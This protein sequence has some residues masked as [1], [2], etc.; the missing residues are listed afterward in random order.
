[1]AVSNRY[2]VAW[3]AIGGS[4]SIIGSLV[5]FP[6]G[7]IAMGADSYGLWIVCFSTTTLLAQADFGIG[8]AVV[9]EVAGSTAS[10][11]RAGSRSFERVSLTF[12]FVLA[13]SLSALQLVGLGM[14]F[15]IANPSESR[16][17]VEEF[18]LISSVGLFFALLGRYFVAILQAHQRFDTERKAAVG[19]VALRAVL[20]SAALAVQAPAWV[21]A[22]A[23]MLGVV[24]PV[25]VSVW[26]ALHS[27]Y[28]RIQIPSLRDFRRH[29]APLLRYSGPVFVSAF[30]SLAAMQVPVYIIAAALSPTAVTAYSAATRIYQ[31]ARMT[32]GWVTGPAL[33]EVSRLSALGRLGQMRLI[34]ER[35]L[36]QCV[37][38][39]AA[40]SAVL[41]AAPDLL[42]SVWL[43]DD[44][45]QSAPV[46]QIFGFAVLVFAS[47]SPG[48]VLA[49]ALGRPGIIAWGAVVWLALTAL[50]SHFAASTWGLWGAAA[51]AVMPA[52]VLFPF[53]MAAPLRLTGLRI[54][55]VVVPLVVF[56]ALPTA[57]TFG[58][59]QLMLPAQSSHLFELAVCGAMAVSSSVLSLL[60]KQKIDEIRSKGI[61]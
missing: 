41:F 28:T 5:L 1:M 33:P 12:F 34:H 59:R 3:N 19:G 13:V 29:A 39:G 56:A 36:M 61:K 51:A 18:A 10:D 31:T 24:F 50:G 53:F 14:Y 60:T 16:A 47:Y 46:L 21:V 32:Y 35:L 40:I 55:A 37:A 54:S 15:Q 20:V 38:L 30:S 7:L 4:A 57:L 6:L 42:F 43:G 17:L 45:V 22:F 9:R 25:L 52:V 44:F 23:E 11:R 48:I 8:T 26:I 58:V 2:N 27:R 49:S